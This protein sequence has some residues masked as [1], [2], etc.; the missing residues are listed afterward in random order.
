MSITSIRLTEDID[1][2]LES[3]AKKL[4][5]SKNYLIN[6]AIKEF[7]VKQSLEDS[8]WQDTLVALESIKAGNTL[9]EADVNAWLNSWG[10]GARTPP[11]KS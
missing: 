7:L 3:L 4:D 6:Q 10:T 11:P 1:K 2:P 9:D 5:R 8:R